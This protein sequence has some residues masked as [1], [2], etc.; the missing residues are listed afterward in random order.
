MRR[1]AFE[2]GGGYQLHVGKDESVQAF[3]AKQPLPTIPD[4]FKTNLRILGNHLGLPLEL[5]LMDMSETNYAAAKMVLAI[6]QR[7]F[8][9]N[10]AARKVKLM[11]PIYTWFIQGAMASGELPMVDDWNRHRWQDP[12][13]I[14][15][16]PSNEALSNRIRL[17][18]RQVSLKQIVEEQGGDLE[19]HLAEIADERVMMEE[20][21]ILPLGTPGAMPD[22]GSATGS[23]TG[24]DGEGM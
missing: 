24:A 5:A 3:D 21:G 7:Q 13:S 17:E 10:R 8:A 9:A 11:T 14:S 2:D 4:F 12:A 20:K 23:A 1:S 19:E 15:A 6:A 18:T 16:D 22:Q